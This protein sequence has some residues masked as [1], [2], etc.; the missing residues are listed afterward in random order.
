MNSLTVLT[1]TDGCATSSA[2]YSPIIAIGDAL[3]G[4]IPND[5][6]PQTE[7]DP[8]LGMAEKAGAGEQAREILSTDID[9][10]NP[11]ASGSAEGESLVGRMKADRGATRRLRKPAAAVQ[12]QAAF[13]A[14]GDAAPIG[15]DEE[16]ESEEEE[17]SALVEASP[18]KAL[19]GPRKDRP[20][21]GGAV[22]SVPRRKDD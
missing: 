7:S 14:S 1:G 15:L 6:T 13:E 10:S 16:D 8:Y 18:R 9:L 5:P 20:K 17:G 4:P 3:D 21:L 12:T 19:P 11:A 2:A 22:P